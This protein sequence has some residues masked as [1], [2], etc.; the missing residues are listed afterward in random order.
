MSHLLAFKNMSHLAC[1]TVN[2]KELKVALPIGPDGELAF[3]AYQ[4]PPPWPPV[5]DGSGQCYVE[6]NRNRLDFSDEKL[7]EIAECFWH[8]ILPVLTRGEMNGRRTKR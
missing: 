3:L 4:L 7:E 5:S 8:L 1:S 2:V 6:V